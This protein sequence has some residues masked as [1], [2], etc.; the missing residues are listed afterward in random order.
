MHERRPCPNDGLSVPVGGPD[1][2][3]GENGSGKRERH[4]RRQR[5]GRR[6]TRGQALSQGAL[7]SRRHLSVCPSALPRGSRP[8][9]MCPQSR[10]PER[11]VTGAHCLRARTGEL[12]KTTVRVIRREAATSP[13]H[14]VPWSRTAPLGSPWEAGGHRETDESGSPVPPHCCRGAASARRRARCRTAPSHGLC[15]KLLVPCS[16]ETSPPPHLS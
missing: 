11:H 7:A 14:S 13:T 5:Q 10:M 12:L 2:A 9:R 4:P 1:A 15:V 16:L 6:A 3:R 8:V